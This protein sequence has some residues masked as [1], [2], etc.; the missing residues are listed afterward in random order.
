MKK[1]K[2]STRRLALIFLLVTFGWCAIMVRFAQV[3]I[4]QGA[5]YDDLVQRQCWG[6]FE[7]SA[8]RG[9][10]YDCHENPL[11]IDIPTESFYTYASSKGQLRSM[12]NAIGRVIGD[13]GLTG[14]LLSR[15]GKFNWLIRNADPV[16]ADKIK[17]LDIDSVLLYGDAGEFGQS[18][19]SKIDPSAR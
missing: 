1:A 11:V 13:S 7:L 14:R 9:N 6:E 8:R 18:H 2:I 16:V 15:P 12:G 17:A 3:Q 19:C 5:R 4:A 10:I